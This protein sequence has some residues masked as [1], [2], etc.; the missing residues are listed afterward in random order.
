M[1][2]RTYLSVATILA[3]APL[4]ASA[5]HAADGCSNIKSFD[6][7]STFDDAFRNSDTFQHPLTGTCIDYNGTASSW[8]KKI[9]GVLFQSNGRL[10]FDLDGGDDA[11][12][13]LRGKSLPNV[14]GRTYTLS[15]TAKITENPADRQFTIGQLFAVNPSGTGRPLVR[16]EISDGALRAVIKKNLGNED[17]S[18]SYVPTGSAGTVTL[19]EDISYSITQTRKNSTTI[20]LKVVVE[21][22]TV[23]NQDVYAKGGSANYF[24]LG[25]YMNNSTVLNGCTAEF[26]AISINPDI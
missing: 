25:C 22:Q 18:T 5:A 3:A 10:V 15:A 16:I 12:A 7:A 24:K 6:Y 19:N 23:F 20:T 9:D 8:N 4:F 14:N 11:R 13:E 26:S 17:T 21:G 1:K 2:L